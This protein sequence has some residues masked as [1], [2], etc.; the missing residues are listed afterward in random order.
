V[1]G[2]GTKMYVGD[3][4]LGLVGGLSMPSMFRIGML[5]LLEKH[6]EGCSNCL[7]CSQV[8]DMLRYLL[9]PSQTF[10]APDFVQESFETGSSFLIDN[11]RSLSWWL[12]GQYQA[13][14]HFFEPLT[15]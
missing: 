2:P 9:D 10:L 5:N 3:E 8:H 11:G 6:I 15:S 7:G 14:L 12:S 1:T 13:T 4:M